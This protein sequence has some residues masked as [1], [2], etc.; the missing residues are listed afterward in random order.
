MTLWT[1]PNCGSRKNIICPVCGEDKKAGEKCRKCGS[2]F[3]FTRCSACGF[4]LYHENNKTGG[5]SYSADY[6]EKVRKI[7]SEREKPYITYYE[8]MRI[9]AIA[10]PEDLKELAHLEASEIRELSEL[11]FEKNSEKPLL[12]I[13]SHEL[14]SFILDLKRK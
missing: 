7:I 8:L 11:A 5:E 4:I 6:I 9:A 10:F 3:S 2:E 13:I 12:K 14:A 1:C